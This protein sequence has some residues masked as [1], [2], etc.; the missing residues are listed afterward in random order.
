[1]NYETPE[2]LARMLE[3]ELWKLLDAEYPAMD[4]P[5]EQEPETLR[6]F[7]AAGTSRT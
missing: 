5:D 2:Q 7:G 6:H 4:L 3:A 1:L